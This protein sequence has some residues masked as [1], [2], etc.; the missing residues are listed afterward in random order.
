VHP[1]RRGGSGERLHP[2]REPDD[3]PGEDAAKRRSPARRRVRVDR[4]PAV[5][6]GNNRV[7]ALEQITA[8]LAGL[9]ARPPGLLPA[10][11]NRRANSPSWVITQA[12]D[13]REQLS[14]W[15]ANEVAH[16]HRARCAFRRRVAR[17]LPG[18]APT[19]APTEQHG[20]AP[21]GEECAEIVR[22][23]G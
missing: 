20:V 22:P 4:N 9:R 12:A 14:G 15:S 19:P 8:P 3:D 23:T 21:C 2:L 6:G 10:A 5:G 1:D 13:C 16:R 17:G 18:S 7:G 11:S